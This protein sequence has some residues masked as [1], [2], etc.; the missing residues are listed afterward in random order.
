MLGRKHQAVDSAKLDNSDTSKKIGLSVSQVVV[1]LTIL[2]L[3]IYQLPLY[4]FAS[5]NLELATT[6]GVMTFITM[7][8][9]VAVYSAFWLFVLSLIT[10]KLIKPF[11]ILAALFSS[12]AVY[13]VTTYRVILDKS[14]MSNIFN[15]R[16]EESLEFINPTLILYILLLGVLPAWLLTRLKIQPVKRLRVLVQMV[17]MIVVMFGF[18]YLNSSTWLWFDKHSKSLGGTIMPWSYLAN[19]YRANIE[20]IV[21]EPEQKL[22][23]VATP[24]NDDKMIVVLVIGETARA[25]SFSVYG[26]ERD[27]NPILADSDVAVLPGATSCSTYTT[28]SIQCM[29]SHDG[30]SSGKH[31]ILPSYLHRHGV[32][33][34][35]RTNNWGEAA[36]TV[37]SYEKAALLRVGCKG[38]YCPFDDV[39]L[40]GL[41]DRIRNSEADKMLVVLHTK[42]S[43]GPAYNS[44]YPAEYEKFTPVCESVELDKC[45]E[46]SL[47]NAY[48]NTIVYTDS[49]LS[50]TIDLIDQVNDTPV[51]MLYASDHGES[52]GEFGLYLH[53]TPYAIAPDVQKD[54]P[55][56]VWMSDEFKNDRGLTSEALETP[57]T[58]SQS[59][60]FHSVMGA[61]EMQSDVYKPE[62][63]IFAVG[64]N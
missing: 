44:R 21:G 38:D 58:H 51:V 1:L 35:W 63:D 18:V 22:L 16:S 28:A 42:G 4:R 9:V 15:T 55:F 49:F 54:I 34:L 5:S 19:T 59:Q 41:Q 62:L 26:Y 32:E 8:V 10:P 17:A 45:S 43:H 20:K 60:I 33:V 52:L 11:C 40:T 30:K 64:A 2:N 7:L 53:G 29:L 12:V 31:E 57:D 46:Q 13:F 6:N 37:D 50:R 27:T 61:F 56:I 47:T 23:P 36:I 3:L 14:M 48:D 24:T 39:L 25:Q